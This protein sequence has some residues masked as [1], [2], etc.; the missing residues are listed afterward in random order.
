MLSGVNWLRPLCPD[1]SCGL[2]VS[3]KAMNLDMPGYTNNPS[4]VYYTLK[5][6]VDAA[7]NFTRDTKAGFQIL[8]EVVPNRTIELAVPPNPTP[9]QLQQLQRAVDYANKQGIKLNINTVK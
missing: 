9:G 5:K 1:L 6:Y 3:C 2:A 4:A 7:A 8:G